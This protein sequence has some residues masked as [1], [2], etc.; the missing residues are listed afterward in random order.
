MELVDGASLRQM[1]SS[2]ALPEKK[3]LEIATQIAEGL[4]KAHSAGIVHRT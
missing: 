3:M 2:G 4:A 1:L